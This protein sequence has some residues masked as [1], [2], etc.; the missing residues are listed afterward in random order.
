MNTHRIGFAVGIAALAGLCVMAIH[1]LVKNPVE[2]HYGDVASLIEADEIYQI[3][4]IYNGPE[5]SGLDNQSPAA[6]WRNTIASRASVWAPIVEAP[7]PPVPPPDWKK[8]LKGISLSKAFIGEGPDRKVKIL[9]NPKDTVGEWVGAGS[10]VNGLLIKEV[11]DRAVVFT[12]FANGK[13]YE[14]RMLFP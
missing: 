5:G 14:Y 13:E 2:A 12:T 10:R 7:P 6:K 4:L 8:L 11:T 9:K 3:S 1:N